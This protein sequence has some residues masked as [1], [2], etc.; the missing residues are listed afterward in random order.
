MISEKLKQIN[1]HSAAG[2]FEE[3]NRSLFYRKSLAIRRY[4]ET[5]PLAK[6][7]G[8]LLYPCGI[9]EASAAVVPNFLS[10]IQF[11]SKKLD[12][13]KISDIIIDTFFKYK[14]TLPREHT[15]AGNMFTHSHP[16]YER[17]LA[18]GLLSYI[19]RINKITD[20]DLRDGLLHVISGIEAYL[21]RII[22]Y[23]YTVNA[24]AKLITALKRVP[25]LPATNIYEAI[26]AWN[27]VMYLDNCDN[28]GC[29]A[30][31]LYPYYNGEDI[32]ELL[33]QL[34]NNLDLNGGYSMAL[35]SNYTPLT[36]QCLEASKG[37]RRPMI[38]LFV[39][40]DTPDEIWSKAFEVI[41]TSNGQPAFYNDAELDLL[42][43]RIASI[44][45]DDL[46]RFCGGGCTEAMLAG[47]SNVGSLDA[48][49]NLLLILENCIYEN[50]S[51]SENFEEFYSVF[52]Q[53]VKS[54]V[55]EICLRISQSQLL[56]AKYNPL[57]MRTL[58]V[59]D[60]IDN[61]LDFNN[62]GARYKWSI[63]NFAGMINVIDSLYVIK[64]LV[65]EEKKISAKELCE[66]LKANNKELLNQLKRHKNAFG[67]DIDEVNSFTQ[68]LSSDIYSLLDNKA[69]ALGEA[70]I[71]ASIQFLS[72]IEA[73]KRVG[74][75]PDGRESGAPLC[76]SLGAIFSKDTNGPTSLIKSVTSLDLSRAV[77]IPVL[78]FNVNPD[79]D[80]NALKG[81][82]KTYMSLGGLQIQLTY[83]SRDELLKAYDDP[84]A[85]KNLVVR[86]G[87]YS[88]YFYRL[89]D[90]L[91]KLVINRTIQNI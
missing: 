88:E 17:I 40:P 90:D 66:G 14:S 72:Q 34:Y 82:I 69:P 45:A 41:R 71:P 80:E 55:E 29:V 57:P 86:V 42:K 65:Y 1:E 26:V 5:C 35:S 68:K 73:G 23:L 11:D 46:K 25:L 51:I 64:D 36:L 60:C 18:E 56:R 49:V 27:F 62:G 70:F 83:S 75:T 16:N 79:F 58:F 8:E 81:L 91:K 67:K 30:D 9:L 32:T 59:D 7:N 84:E 6:Y 15:V 77:G 54:V 53:N 50:L 33:G 12:N 78:N 76:D 13:K 21:N 61:G 4:Y 19:E 20:I 38:E 63:I 2:L 85:Y 74:A 31:G 47:V 24:E 22:E 43:K 3:E 89:T 10:G 48:G 39:N 87:G 28:L 52:T 44:K 37:K